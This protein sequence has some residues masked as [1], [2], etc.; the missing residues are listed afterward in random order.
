MPMP[1]YQKKKSPLVIAMIVL[2][3]LILGAAA[4]LGFVGFCNRNIDSALSSGGGTD[5]MCKLSGDEVSTWEFDKVGADRYYALAYNSYFYYE[6]LGGKWAQNISV[7]MSRDNSDDT[8]TVIYYT[9]VVDGAKGEYIAPLVRAED[10]LY[11]ANLN[12]D[13]LFAIRIYPTEKVRTTVSFD[14]ATL[15]Y[16]IQREEFSPARVILWVYILLCLSLL[17]IFVRHRLTKKGRKPN[18]IICAY[19]FL[20]TLVMLAAFQ[21]PRMFTAVAGLGNILIFASFVLFSLLYISIYFIVFRIHNAPLK[22]AAC[23]LLCGTIFSFASAPMQAPDEYWH[24]LRAYTISSGD[25]TF[26]NSVEYPDEV[27]RLVDSFPGNF[28]KEVQQKGSGSVLQSMTEFAETKD[29]PY[30]GKTYSSPIQVIVPYIPSAMGIAAGH[31][32]G[33]ELAA[34]YLGRLMNVLTLAVCA[35]FALKW[36]ERYRGAII[37]TALFPLTLFLCASYSYDAMFIACVILMFGILFKKDIHLSDLVILCVTF[38]MIVSVKPLYFPL[39]LLIFAVPRDSFKLGKYP[40][41]TA[42][43]ALALGGALFYFATLAYAGAFARGIP[44]VGSPDGVNVASQINYILGN[45]IRYG[46]T[47][48]VDGYMNCFYLD[49]LGLFGWL[50]A[51]AVLTSLLCPIAVVVVS[52]LYSE[53]TAKRKKSDKWIFAGIILF[54]YALV[55]T[56]FYCTWSTLGSTSILGVQ[57]RYFIPV[58]PCI[59]GVLSSLFGRQLRF[60]SSDSSK[61]DSDRDSLGIYICTCLGLVAAFELALLYFFT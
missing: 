49:E 59:V 18:L 13:E 43:G 41:I 40:R 52:L 34:F 32:F 61:T 46:L 54:I 20:Q 16:T 10:G 60:V 2:V 7:A 25:F 50:D 57:A 1:T 51:N 28:Y 15:N 27:L 45:P 8:E 3:L 48:A 14:G 23:V 33:S 26:D 55:V 30:I 31:L 58:L 22:L 36:A 42:L 12:A 35:Y 9:A 24:Y 11:T 19:V 56:G 39:A 47:A 6:N 53:T 44:P 5:V 4:E 29:E 17:Y 21:A 37:V 38:G